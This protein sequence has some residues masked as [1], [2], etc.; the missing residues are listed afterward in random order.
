MEIDDGFGPR[1][2]A[3]EDGIFPLAFGQQRGQRMDGGGFRTAL[4]RTEGMERTGVALPA[5]IGQARR[6]DTLAAQDGAD[7]ASF[8]GL[9]GLRQDVQLVLDG[10][11]P[12]LGAVG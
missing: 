6:V 8:G 3:C 12:P 4:T 2:A 7:P 1:Q 11:A 9:V 5:P 10:E